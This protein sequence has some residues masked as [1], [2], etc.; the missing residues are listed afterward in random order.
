[1]VAHTGEL[2]DHGRDASER[3]QF[4]VELEPEPLGSLA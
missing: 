3:P 2:L 4:G 1:M